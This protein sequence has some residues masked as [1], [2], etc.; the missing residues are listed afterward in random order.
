MGLL[1]E[2]M[3]NLGT[4]SPEAKAEIKANAM[5]GTA[6]D[7]WMPNPGP[8][9]E[10][11]FCDADELYFG[12]ESGGGKSDLLIGL[13]LTAHKNSLLLRRINDDA[14][15]MADRTVEILGHT[16]GLNRTTLEWRLPDRRIDFGGC[17]LEDDRHRYKGV[18]HSLIGFDE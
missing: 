17:Q 14:R 2:V 13:A 4:L 15:G 16:T 12:G 5:A 1:E 10:A 11:Y 3:A 8:Q 9:T 18:A 7:V 6:K